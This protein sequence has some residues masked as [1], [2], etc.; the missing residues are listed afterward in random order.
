MKILIFFFGAVSI[1]AQNTLTP[2]V[3]TINVRPGGSPQFSL[4]YS[5][6]GIAA[7]QWTT[8]LTNLNQTPAISA[9]A[10]ATA[11]QKQINC[12]IPSPSNPWI[13]IGYGMNQN[14]M[15]TGEVAKYSLSIPTSQPPGPVTLTFSNPLAV[16]GPGANVPLTIG[17]SVTIN[18][19]SKYDIDGDGA[20]NATDVSLSAD[21]AT[22]KTSCS[23][24]MNGDSVCDIRD[25]FLVILASLG[26]I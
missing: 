9:G 25:T 3:A 17:G 2:S 20:I 26:V 18:V 8:T 23:A 1:F 4:N 10:M 6:T 19:L 24:D 7:V 16:N 15:T 12:Y 21:M 5:G 11:Q 14:L 13:C 22:G